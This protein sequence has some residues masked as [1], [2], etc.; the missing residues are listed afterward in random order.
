LKKLSL[1]GKEGKNPP[2][3]KTLCSLR[4]TSLD[5]RDMDIS[6]IFHYPELENLDI[7]FDYGAS[8]GDISSCLSMLYQHFPKLKALT[9]SRSKFKNNTLSP[10]FALLK[11]LEYLYFYETHVRAFPKEIAGLTKLRELIFN[12]SY[13]TRVRKFPENLT[14]IP[15]LE[16][17][18]FHQKIN[19]LPSSIKNMKTLRTL[20]ITNAFP[21]ITGLPEVLKEMTW[22]DIKHGF[23]GR[24]FYTNPHYGE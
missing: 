20:D 2:I 3:P 19:G 23:R 17:L 8:Y 13:E 1:A 15:H 4:L 10:E 16:K 5:I 9:L 22:A 21:L 12:E 6:T 7:G 14:L 18:Y 24:I 11:N